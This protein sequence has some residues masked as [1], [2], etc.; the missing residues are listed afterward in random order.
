MINTPKFWIPMLAFQVIFGLAVFF[1][2]RDYYMQEP[3]I[4]A[5]RSATASSQPPVESPNNTGQ[6]GSALIGSA[7]FQ[8]MTK[9]DPDEIA[10]EANSLFANG[11]YN[12]AATL[13]RQLLTLGR[14]NAD[15]YNNLGITLHYLGRS[16]D[17]LDSLNKGI[18][19]DP[20][21]QRIWLTSGYVNGQL[22]N[23][24]Q[25][26]TALASAVELNP[27]SDVGQSAQKMLEELP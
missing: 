26:R 11:Q 15:T 22:G 10:R 25:A 3:E 8:Q 27:D 19:K 4:P 9:K 23:F 24:E 1:A 6:S 21:Y 2:T 13:Y 12:Q 14:D 7:T 18:A 20:S 16:G 17:A 5:T